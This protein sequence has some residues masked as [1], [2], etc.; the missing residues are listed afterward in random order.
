MK[1]NNKFSIYYFL[2]IFFMIF[3]IDSMF[4][5]AG[6]TGSQVL[7]Y[8]SFV[9]KVDSGGVERVV[10]LPDKIVG[11]LKSEKSDTVSHE[12][13][14]GPSAPWRLRIREIEEQIARQFTVTR[15]PNVSDTELL[16]RLL[17]NNVQVVGKYQ[18]NAMKNFFLNWIFP[19][20]FVMA[21]WGY[22]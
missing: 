9:Q 10:I 16:N 15:L 4:F 11:E 18:S 19:L 17:E 12:L 6:K 5:S 14:K 13:T 2:G 22:I 7:T 8:D 3:L 20:I 21:L 1:K